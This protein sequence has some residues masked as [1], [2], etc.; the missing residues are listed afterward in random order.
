MQLAAL[1]KV[2]DLRHAVY[3]AVVVIP[4]AVLQPGGLKTTGIP[5]ATLVSCHHWHGLLA[6]TETYKCTLNIWLKFVRIN[7]EVMYH[8]AT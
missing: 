4:E 1:F 5:L 8:P 7:P 3:G 2:Q 6:N